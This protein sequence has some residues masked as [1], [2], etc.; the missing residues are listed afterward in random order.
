MF[1][2]IFRYP[3]KMRLHD[4]VAIQE[5]HLSIRF[6]PDLQDIWVTRRKNM[7]IGRTLYF[8]YCAIWS[9][10]VTC[11]LNFPLLLNFPKQVPTLTKFGRATE[12]LM[13]IDDS[14]T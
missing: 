10:A 2:C 1:G 7:F 8:A 12:M 14:E 5:W 3:A 4:M 13:R 6:D 11:S 9:S